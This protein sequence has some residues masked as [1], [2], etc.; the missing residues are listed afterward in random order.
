MLI[1]LIVQTVQKTFKKFNGS[2]ESLIAER[3]GVKDSLLSESGSKKI[4]HANVSK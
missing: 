2:D 3:Q 1:I 4:K